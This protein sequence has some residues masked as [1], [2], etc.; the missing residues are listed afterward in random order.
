MVKETEFYDRLGVSPNADVNEI[1][2]AYRKLAVKWHPDKNPGDKNAEEQFKKITEA[3]EVLSDPKKRQLYDEYGQDGLRESGFNP[4]DAASIFEQFFGPFGFSF[5]GSRRN[6]RSGPVRGK[7]VV[8]PLNLTLEDLYNGVTKKMKVTRNIICKACNGTGTKD[9]AAPSKCSTCGGSGMK[10]TVRQSGNFIQQ[11]QTMCPTCQGSGEMIAPSDQ[12]ATC[13]GE[14]TVQVQKV[15][16]V[17]VEKGMQQGQKIVFYGESDEAPGTLPGDLIFI[18]KEK[19]HDVFK[20]AGKDLVMEVD[21]PLVNALCG[22]EKVI[23]HLDGHEIIIKTKEGEIIK[24][25]D[26]REVPG[27]GMPIHKTPYEYGSLFIKFN[28]IFPDKLSS[29]AIAKLKEHL[30]DALPKVHKQ[31]SAI[32]VQMIKVNPEKFNQR[33]R[34]ASREERMEEEEMGDDNYHSGPTA[35]CVQQ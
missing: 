25:G 33:K 15:L 13:K 32:E 3:Y 10:I 30:P 21:L 22:F 5:G 34:R 12:C 2:K 31:G 7:D 17:E 27:Q 24:P 29:K 26:I 9:G 14:K 1:K 23:K 11:T 35:Q 18:I 20:R 16:E 19:E 8:Y 4:A 6:Q 28:V